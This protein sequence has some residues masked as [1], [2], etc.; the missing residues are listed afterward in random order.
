M[1]QHH[2]GQKCKRHCTLEGGQVHMLL[3]LRNPLQRKFI[4]RRF[5]SPT[6]VKRLH[7]ST[8]KYIEAQGIHL[9]SF[10]LPS[11]RVK[12]SHGVPDPSR[13]RPLSTATSGHI[14]GH[15]SSS[16]TSKGLLWCMATSFGLILANRPRL[17]PAIAGGVIA[18]FRRASGASGALVGLQHGVMRKIKIRPQVSFFSCVLMWQCLAYPHLP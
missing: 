5:E 10:P 4:N 12:F 7:R 17:I 15:R 13:A 16:G 3:F 2:C 8:L 1:F 9:P 6:D 11:C 18:P 14:D